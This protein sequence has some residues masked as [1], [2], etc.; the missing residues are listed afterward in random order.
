[1]VD[2]NDEDAN[3]LRACF[4]TNDDTLGRFADAVWSEGL[5]FDLAFGGLHR[6]VDRSS[7]KSDNDRKQL[8]SLFKF[9]FSEKYRLL[10][11]VMI[12]RTQ[13]NRARRQIQDSYRVTYR[14]GVQHVINR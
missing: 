2:D 1:M 8:A 9:D 11:V 7:L 4:H 10:I 3:W 14:W 12:D 5:D 13:H 6:W